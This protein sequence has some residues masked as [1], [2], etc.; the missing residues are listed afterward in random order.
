L[1]DF[2][3]LQ[4][5]LCTD[6]SRAWENQA[7]LEHFPVITVPK[8]LKLVNTWAG[9]TGLLDF[10]ALNLRTANDLNY[11]WSSCAR[12]QTFPACLFRDAVTFNSTWWRCSALTNFQARLNACAVGATYNNGWTQTNLS[13]AAKDQILGDINTANAA[14]AAAPNNKI[15]ISGGTPLGVVGQG[16]LPT[17]QGKGWDTQVV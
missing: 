17:L 15:T 16:L 11:T 14:P 9:C 1:V 12:I 8:V 10:P 7:Y 2:P 6:L 3:A 4:L 5:P 13:E